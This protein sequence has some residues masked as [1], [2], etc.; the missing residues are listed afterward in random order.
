MHTWR[1]SSNAKDVLFSWKP[2]T[3]MLIKIKTDL[4][5]KGMQ[6]KQSDYAR[7]KRAGKCLLSK[8]CLYTARMKNTENTM[9]FARGK[10]DLTSQEFKIFSAAKKFSFQQNRSA[11]LVVAPGALR[12][13]SS[14]A[15]AL[16]FMKQ[17][18][19]VIRDIFWN[20]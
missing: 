13:G 18:L 20:N 6:I 12:G 1:N 10:G 7:D 5:Q 11:L 2:A 4:F 14:G 17:K 9:P 19:Y 3:E 15:S 16:T 8:V